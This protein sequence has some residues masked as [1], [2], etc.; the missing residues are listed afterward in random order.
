MEDEYW[1]G[2]WE[3]SGCAS[4][5]GGNTDLISAKA[6]NLLKQIRH[7]V[8]ESAVNNLFCWFSH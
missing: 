4:L 6:L 7:T 1:L 2:S 8:V 3:G 5:G